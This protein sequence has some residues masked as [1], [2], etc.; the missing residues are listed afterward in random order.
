MTGVNRNFI[1]KDLLEPIR[2]DFFNIIHNIGEIRLGSILLHKQNKFISFNIKGIP[3]YS[4][5]NC[6]FNSGHTVIPE[7]EKVNP[8]KNTYIA[9]KDT[10]IK[11]MR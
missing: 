6:F 8:K 10:L 5:K 2:D 11:N 9:S 1:E 7:K 3:D 4:N